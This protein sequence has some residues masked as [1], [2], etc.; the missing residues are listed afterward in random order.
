MKSA[1]FLVTVTMAWAAIACGSDSSKQVGTPTPKKKEA[2]KLQ[3]GPPA[4]GAGGNQRINLDPKT[5]VDGPIKLLDASYKIQVKMANFTLCDGEIAVK[6]TVDMADLEKGK[7]LELPAGWV[8][9]T[10]VGKIDLTAIL[11][12]FSTS[13]TMPKL[14][15]EKG[16]IMLQEFGQATYSPP[17]PFLPS[18]LAASKKQL[19]NLN[20]STNLSITDRKAGVTSKGTAS[21]EMLDFNGTFS[22]RNIDRRFSKVMHFRSTAKG[23]NDVDKISNFLFDALEIKLN[24]API[25][26]LSISA[27]GQVGGMTSFAF[28]NKDKL[29]ADLVTLLDLLPSKHNPG[30]PLSPL[31]GGLVDRIANTITLTSSLEI[32]KYDGPEEEPESGDDEDKFGETE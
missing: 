4:A 30:N 29:P 13:A 15:V 2:Q 28:E 22:A 10:L 14:K 16:V 23:F 3:E 18:F 32:S 17:R 8:D 19:N 7:F 21:V 20:Y 9:C 27:K 25:A 6:V 31:L 5:L 1:A 12:I 26:L 24:L 11:G